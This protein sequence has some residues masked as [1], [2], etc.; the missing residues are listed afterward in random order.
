MRPSPPTPEQ[1][2]LC[3]YCIDT[4]REFDVPFEILTLGLL[5]NRPCACC[6]ELRK[7]YL[8]RYVD[9]TQSG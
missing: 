7:S 9:D 4:L 6:K 5:T 8:V 1:E 2:T 3:E